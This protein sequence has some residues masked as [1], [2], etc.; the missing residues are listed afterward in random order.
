[1][2]HTWGP[3]LNWVGRWG[4]TWLVHRESFHGDVENH[5]SSADSSFAK[6]MGGTSTKFLLGLVLPCVGL[7]PL[8]CVVIDRKKFA[9]L[10]VNELIPFVIPFARPFPTQERQVSNQASLQDCDTLVVKDT[11]FS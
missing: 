2:N 9:S 11:G 4:P 3:R 6:V 5:G 1:M 10:A 7:D 8:T